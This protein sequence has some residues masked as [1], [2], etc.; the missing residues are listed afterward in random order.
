[1]ILKTV[2]IWKSV[3]FRWLSLEVHEGLLCELESKLNENPR[4]TS[5]LL[6]TLDRAWIVAVRL[7]CDGT[8]YFELSY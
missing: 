4:N 2:L 5:T 8:K 6:V 1:M 7:A 3:N